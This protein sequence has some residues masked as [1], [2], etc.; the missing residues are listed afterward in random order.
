MYKRITHTADNPDTLLPYA[1]C[2]NCRQ[3]T[4]EEITFLSAEL[5]NLHIKGPIE[6]GSLHRHQTLICAFLPGSGSNL[7]HGLNLNPSLSCL[8]MSL[9]LG[10]SGECWQG[11]CH[12]WHFSKP[13]L[14]WKHSANSRWNLKGN[15]IRRKS[16][17]RL[18]HGHILGR[19]ASH[20][21]PHPASLHR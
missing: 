4:T 9:R 10:Q 5:A 21:N 7:S 12:C 13:H 2:P 16:L 17:Q 8:D 20:P 3:N 14:D 11:V 18:Y 15:F 1:G 6:A 19:Q